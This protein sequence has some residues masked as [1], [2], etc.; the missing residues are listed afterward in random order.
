MKKLFGFI[1]A[2]MLSLGV[3]A[4][5]HFLVGGCTASGWNAGLW[6][7]S[8]VQMVKVGETSEWICCLKLTVG[9]GDNGRF[10]IPNSADGWDGYWAPAQGTVLTPEWSDMTTNGGGDNKWCVAEEGVY[11]V[12]I[13]TAT[14]KIKAEKLTA[15][16]KDGDF[17][18]VGSENDYYYAVG[19][20]TSGE[21]TSKIRLTAD[22]NFAGKGF[23][24][25]ASD[26]QKFKSEIDGAGHTINNA[27]IK[28]DGQNIGLI[29]YASDGA[30]IHD[31]V[32]GNGCS[33][34]GVAKVGGLVGFARDGGNITLSN[35][36][37][38][39]TVR[40]TGTTDANAAGL[41]GCC[42]DGTKV[43]AKNCAVTGHVSGQN[44]QC[45]AFT[46]WSQGG[47]TYTNCWAIADGMENLD[48]NRILYRGDAAATNCYYVSEND[49][50]QGTKVSASKV[51]SG[52]F[53]YMLNGDQSALGWYQNLS[54][55]VDATPVP[56]SSH[57]QVYANG[58][59]K[60]DGTSAGG[61]LTYSNSN[62]SVI[63][64]HTNKN[65]WCTVCGTFHKEYLT[66][67]GGY[68]Q[69]GNANDLR[70][71][72]S[73]VM[74][75]DA[76]IKAQLT[77]DIDY[78][79]YNNGFIGVPGLPF[80]G[81][82]DGQ[83]HTIKIAIANR[84]GVN[85]TGLFAAIDGATIKNLAVEGTASSNDQNC[86]GG[87]GG[88]S[89]GTSTIENVIVKTAVS[90]T[91]G[92]S[93]ATCGG[94]FANMEGVATLKNCA[95]LGSINTGS[96]EGNGGLVGWAGSGSNNKYINCYVAPSAYTKNGNSADY[97][98]N[99]P[100][101]TNCYVID[102]ADETLA[103]GELCFNLNGNVSGGENWYQAL[104]SDA[105]PVPF[106]SHGKV[107]QNG[108]YYCDH[109]TAKG[110][111]SYSN[112]EGATY[113]DHVFGSN[114]L[115]ENCKAE[116]KEP[117][118][119]VDVYQIANIGQLVWFAT[120]VNGGNTTAKAELTADIE[121]GDAKLAPIGT[122]ANPYHAKFIGNFHTVTLA[123]ESDNDYQGLFGVL[124][125][126]AEIYN[127][128]TAGSVKGK[129]FVGGIAGGTNGGGDVK[130]INVGN[131]AT[132][133]ATSANA[134][135]ILGVDMGS[136]A[137]ITMINVYNAGAIKGAK[138]NGGLSGWAGDQPFIINAYN[139]AEAENGD[140]FLR[141]NGAQNF[142]NYYGKNDIN[143]TML[144]SGELCAKLD[145]TNFRQEVGT[146]H[147]VFD[148]TLPNVVSATV[149]SA[150]YA[151]YVADEDVKFNAE[152]LEAYVV[153][154]TDGYVKLESVT[155]IPAYK[156]VILEANEEGTYYF[157]TTTDAAAPAT[158]LLV[159]DLFDVTADGT[160][161][162]LAQVDGVVGF[163]KAT[164]GTTI[165]A[166]KGYLVVTG[167]DVKAFY[168]FNDN[169]E[170]AISEIAN[171][172]EKAAIYNLQG[173][174]LMNAQ[175]G[176]N[177]IGDKK[178]VIK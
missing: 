110:S 60:C 105:T 119:D 55:D 91:G 11:I 97:A 13:N 98:R 125:N 132:V 6:Q 86:V 155:E 153:S 7:R 1:A 113:D 54:T 176:I 178:V 168:G 20:I 173:V 159:A 65:G 77:A 57:S 64:P 139:I 69:I 146:G 5:E 72:G 78:T 41:I 112:V 100:A 158:N 62:E 129:S 10:K 143:E 162:I 36:I 26:K 61:E 114:D 45:G 111:S 99:N 96:A 32:L 73:Y 130:F 124:T 164:E 38:A 22:L 19:A 21:T 12:T 80:K 33:F 89:D 102:S 103:S 161:Y 94:F 43:T 92:N 88:R 115:C 49:F 154:A 148:Q 172:S 47:S 138:E 85:R 16:S 147:P 116:G 15:P 131:E 48:G 101:L 174:K 117:A 123:M 24:P 121:Q 67:V 84:A 9:D 58:T 75:I 160:Q 51:A 87:L 109:V 150:R 128:T 118:K 37:S 74:D 59:L 151:T 145:D 137:K 108:D 40:S 8:Q 63:P 169:N 156:A 44:G 29:R 142:V 76:T 175:K 141:C 126:G 95:F 93:D 34:T 140:G 149:S 53:C 171:N 134:G 56:F 71:F 144:T 133:E 66:P 46:G 23:F 3:N 68:Y 27:V 79:A 120:S 152:G 135:G 30:N 82:F 166:G 4:E 122:Q 104:P 177:I 81:E 107:Y 42:T 50:G 14:Q 106:A 28:D 83:E 136:A 157:N 31:L 165:A 163:K 18:L 52:E 170:T 17:Y 35:I 90:Y 167:N 25:L 70:W 39:G 127:L 2:V